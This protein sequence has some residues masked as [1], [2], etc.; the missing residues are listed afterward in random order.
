MSTKLTLEQD[1]AEFYSNEAF[2]WTFEAAV[3]AR[4]V[5][6]Y[7]Q[8]EGKKLR[9]AGFELQK[10][11]EG[12]YDYK[13]LVS[14]EQFYERLANMFQG[15]AELVLKMEERN[16][17]SYTVTGEPRRPEGAEGRQD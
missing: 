6:L 12:R 4:K 2:F 3:A 1:A 5:W 7:R 10:A 15:M 14:D 8:S 9:L 13:V 17:C 16:G 11:I